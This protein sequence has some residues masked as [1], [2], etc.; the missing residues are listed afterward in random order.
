MRVVTRT[1]AYDALFEEFF[2]IYK[3]RPITSN[4]GGM[5]LPHMFAT[6]VFIRESEP[7]VVL[8]SGIWRGQSTWLIEQATNADI[9]SVDL[10][11]GNRAYI[12]KRAKYVDIDFSHLDLSALPKT[13]TVL[14]FDDH[15]NAFERLMQ[16]RAWGFANFI[17]EDNYPPGQGDIPSL[18][19]M[20]QA[21]YDAYGAS[22]VAKT[23]NWRD[24]VKRNLR[25]LV[26]KWDYR[27]E[28]YDPAML[29]SAL[30][31][32]DYDY[33]E[34]P[35]LKTFP[36]TRWGTDWRATYGDVQACLDP[37]KLSPEAAALVD[38]E[39]RGYTSICSVRLPQVP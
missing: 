9:I 8:E 32:L 37:A 20:Q 33:E 10:E 23:R 28:R 15:V 24:A 17:F 19:Q 5:L 1:R 38:R 14:F 16:G 11:L 29:Q 27:A 7:E 21:A 12:S 35:P 36:D 18:K 2:D 6:W 31:A 22:R 4:A 25:P 13:K 39:G 3:R 34:F 30:A 26:A